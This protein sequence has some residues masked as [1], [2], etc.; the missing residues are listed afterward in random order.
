[1]IELHYPSAPIPKL[2]DA[3]VDLV[4]HAD[5]E[6]SAVVAFPGVLVEFTRASPDKPWTGGACTTRAT[7]TPIDE[8]YITAARDLAVE[9]LRRELAARGD[10][11]GVPET[12]RCDECHRIIATPELGKSEGGRI[13]KIEC[14]VQHVITFSNRRRLFVEAS[15]IA[16]WIKS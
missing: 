5:E 7:S 14:G 15:G 9:A 11:A 12:V 4:V 13:T 6:S 8:G 1:M 3:L 10:E 16:R 2:G